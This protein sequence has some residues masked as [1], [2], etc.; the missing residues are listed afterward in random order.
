MAAKRDPLDPAVIAEDRATLRALEQLDDYQLSDPALSVEALQRLEADMLDAEEDD[1]QARQ[2]LEQARAVRD[3]ALYAFI[4]ALRAA[5]R[6]FVVQCGDSGLTVQM[7]ELLDVWED[8]PP[9][10]LALMA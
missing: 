10:P 5:G 9:P 1:E 3:R 7:I 2:A 6:N 8:E 4:A